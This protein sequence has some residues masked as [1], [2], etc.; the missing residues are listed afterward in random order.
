MNS[1]V[2]AD[3]AV[4]SHLETL[5]ARMNLTSILQAFDSME[6]DKLHPDTASRILGLVQQMLHL[7]HGG[8]EVLPE[9]TE[10]SGAYPGRRP[11]SPIGMR[12]G[13]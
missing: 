8:S 10:A 3:L 4:S 2:A 12:P 13:V 6:W 9:R 7:V 5:M 11:N 1:S